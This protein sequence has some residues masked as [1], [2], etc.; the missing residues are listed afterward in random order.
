MPHPILILGG[1]GN[2]GKRIAQRLVNDGLDVIIAGR[3]SSKAQALCTELSDTTKSLAFDVETGLDYALTQL[4][5]K[6]V[7][8]TCGP[9]QSA[10]YKIAETCIQHGVHYIDL[11][12][13][14]DFVTGI[15]SLDAQAKAQ[16]VTVISGAS[17]VPGLS[18]AVL[19]H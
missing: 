11:A 5:P 15:T 19:T 2:F 3:N 7:I 10:D 14:R 16:N 18:S 13:G 8:N 17:T 9:F 12:D 6:V 1:Y 4:R